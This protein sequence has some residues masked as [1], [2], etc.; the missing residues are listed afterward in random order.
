[1]IRFEFPWF[2]LGFDSNFY[3]LIWDS[4]R[5]F[6]LRFDLMI[7]FD[8]SIRDSIWWFDPGFDEMKWFD[9][10]IWFETQWSH[11]IRDSRFDKIFRD[12]SNPWYIYT[13]WPKKNAH[14][15]HLAITLDADIRPTNHGPFWKAL[16][17]PVLTVSSD[18]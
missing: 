2:D 4:I 9:L 11:V 6:G 17:F 15:F 16:S 1:M 10:M 18:S 13:G 8:D 7:R 3:D 14:L 5:W 12:L